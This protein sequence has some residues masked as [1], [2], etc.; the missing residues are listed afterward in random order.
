M[1][2]LQELRNSISIE[3]GSVEPQKLRAIGNPIDLS[4]YGASQLL[5]KQFVRKD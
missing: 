3:I 1:L 4:V 2:P 5:V